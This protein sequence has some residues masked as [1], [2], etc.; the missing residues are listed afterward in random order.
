MQMN[1]VGEMERC[2]WELLDHSMGKLKDWEKKNEIQSTCKACYLAWVR[3]LDN[4]GHE[5]QKHENVGV[6]TGS[7]VYVFFMMS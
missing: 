5:D 3:L 2:L 6:S 7:R 1:G 4:D